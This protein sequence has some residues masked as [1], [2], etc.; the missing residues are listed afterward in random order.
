MLRGYVLMLLLF[1]AYALSGHVS[2]WATLA[3]F[4]VLALLWP[5]LWRSSMRFRL[6]NTSWRGLR[7]GFEGS[8][9]D[10]YRA[11]LPLFAPSLVFV[12]ANAWFLGKVDKEDPTALAAATAAQ[13]PWVLG[14]SAL[15]ALMFPWCLYL[16][17]RYQHAGY[18]CAQEQGQFNAPVGAFYKLGLK[19]AGVSVLAIGLVLGLV[20]VLMATR[21][22]TGDAA[23]LGAGTAIA[24]GAVGALV[25]L[26]L[27]V[28]IGACASAWTQNLSWNATRSEALGFE[29]RLG[30]KAL[31]WLSM[32]N[33]LLIVLS[34]GLYRPFAVV[35]TMALRLSAVHIT[36]EGELDP[37][38]ASLSQGTRTTSGEMAGDFFG[39]DVGL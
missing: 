7:F 24:L 20:G 34:L 10:A 1:G 27:L 39:I 37:W 25:Y 8:V 29:S 4:L 3:A 15:L 9:A 18:R 33:W 23:G 5:A 26:G 36:L 19:L 2:A 35:S 11:L 21:I 32:K 6:H 16:M 14:G 12:A 17:K 28:L 38:M 13:L 22:R 30:V 31:V